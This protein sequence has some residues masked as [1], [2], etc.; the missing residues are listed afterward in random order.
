MKIIIKFAVLFVAVTLAQT[1]FAEPKI[2]SE[3][4]VIEGKL[5]VIKE[6]RV[7]GV[8]SE[9]TYTS[10]GSGISY[11]IISPTVDGGNQLN[12]HGGSREFSIPSW[13][14]FNW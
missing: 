12:E 1:T 4:I 14:L 2:K 5:G 7:K 11:N 9:I 8:Q 13:T 3:V 6:E 10:S